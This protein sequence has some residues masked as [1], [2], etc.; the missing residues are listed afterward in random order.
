MQRV[1]NDGFGHIEGWMPSADLSHRYAQMVYCMFC[2]GASFSFHVITLLKSG[3]TCLIVERDTEKILHLM[4]QALNF[5]HIFIT[6]HAFKNDSW[7]LQI[8]PFSR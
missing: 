6:S 2:Y 7:P 4:I 3:V 5:H 8:R 1:E